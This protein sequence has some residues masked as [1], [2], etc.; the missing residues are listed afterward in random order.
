MKKAAAWLFSPV[1]QAWALASV[2]LRILRLRHMPDSNRDLAT[3]GGEVA[4]DHTR[5]FSWFGHNQ[6]PNAW[7]LSI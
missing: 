2:P 6:T 7:G 1:E 5:R 3:C 4:V